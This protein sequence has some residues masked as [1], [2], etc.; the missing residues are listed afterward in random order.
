MGRSQGAAGERSASA[1][2]VKRGG[3]MYIFNDTGSV[4]NCNFSPFQSFAVSLQ[5]GSSLVGG[6]NSS[7]GWM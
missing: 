1:H 2:A 6:W 5:N 3:T 4:Y 7:S